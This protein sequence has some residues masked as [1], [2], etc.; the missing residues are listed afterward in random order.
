MEIVVQFI[1]TLHPVRNRKIDIK[2]LKMTKNN[3][4]QD[5]YMIFRKS[6]NHPLIPSHRPFCLSF[7]TMRVIQVKKQ[8]Y[9]RCTL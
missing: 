3:Y 9:T 6:K 1:V 2:E 7:Q 4:Q 8:L 5:F